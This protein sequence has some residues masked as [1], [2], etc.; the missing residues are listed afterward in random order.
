MPIAACLGRWITDRERLAQFSKDMGDIWKNRKFK[1]LDNIMVMAMSNA[2]GAT[3]VHN[4]FQFQ[5][6]LNGDA[7]KG[8]GYI[9]AFRTYLGI[10]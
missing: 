4:P 9:E 1:L 5:H 10:N 7:L 8:V 3:T 2:T 6:F